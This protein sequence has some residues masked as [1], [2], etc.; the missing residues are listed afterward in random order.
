MLQSAA[1]GVDVLGEGLFLMNQGALARA[2][3]VV[4]ERGEWDGIIGVH[5]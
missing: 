3:A 1:H 4:L 2:I 5:D